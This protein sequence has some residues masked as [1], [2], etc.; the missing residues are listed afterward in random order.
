MPSL[1]LAL[2]LLALSL[3]FTSICFIYMVLSHLSSPGIAALFLFFS[4][5]NTFLA[6]LSLSAFAISQNTPVPKW[7]P[8][9]SPIHLLIVLGSGGHTA[10]MFSML[11]RMELDPTKYTYRTYIVS[12]G[13]N[14]SAAKAVEFEASL[15]SRRANPASYAIVTV[16][17][18]RRVHQSYLTAPYTTLLSFWSC[19]L[20]LCGLHPDQQHQTQAQLPSPYPDLILTNGPAT[21]VCVV[22]AARLLRLSHWFLSNLLPGKMRYHPLSIV[23][24]RNGKALQTGQFRLRTVFV[25]SWARVKTL[26]LSGKI[27]LPFADRFLVQWPALEG[28]R[29]WW[30]MR[31]TEYVSGLLD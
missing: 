18:A 4:V 16:P 7:R 10:E 22:L 26:S 5:L 2:G 8:R 11:R 23:G 3:Y 1:K 27:L 19:L 31:K 20:A 9:H 29:A 14:F 17:R 12:S 24:A 21:A 13:D 28:K 25:E 15:V 30:G 6:V